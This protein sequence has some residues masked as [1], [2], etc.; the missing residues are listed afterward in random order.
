MNDVVTASELRVR[1]YGGYELSITAA[2][3]EGSRREEGRSSV[4]APYETPCIV[5]RCVACWA[6]RLH[7]GDGNSS[8]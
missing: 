5:A 4:T 7:S 1:W 3:I 6:Q 8:T 2:F